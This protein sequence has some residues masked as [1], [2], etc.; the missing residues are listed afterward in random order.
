MTDDG[1]WNYRVVRKDGL[2]EYMRPYYDRTGTVH[3]LTIDSV[4][5]TYEDLTD[6]K[7]TLND[8]DRTRRQHY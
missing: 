6:L 4:S 3:S 1:Y 7:T 2:L 5:P 8:A